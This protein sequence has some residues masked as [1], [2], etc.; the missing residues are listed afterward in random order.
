MKIPRISAAVFI[1]L[2]AFASTVAF[3]QALTEPAPPEDTARQSQVNFVLAATIKKIADGDT[4][5]LEGVNKKRFVIRVSD[6][7]TPEIEHAE[8]TPRSCKDC[9]PVPFRP[10][11][12]G[13]KAATEAL[14][15]LLSVGDAVAVEC[16]ELDI[17]GRMVCHIFKGDTNIN[18]E[19]IKNGWGWLPR[20][21]HSNFKTEWIREPASY[22]A[23]RLAKQKSLGAW[24]LSGQVS[25]ARW[26]KD[27]WNNGQCEGAEK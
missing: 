18:L 20:D 22:G 27:C 7:D 1:S 3:S 16:Y 5:I 11:Q 14:K 8:F 26:R 19:M 13:G 25:P 17:Y 12:P 2:A 9:K 10:G 6:M 15:N 4:V 24:G 21:K 23:E